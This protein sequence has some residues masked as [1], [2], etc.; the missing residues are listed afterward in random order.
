LPC[1]TEASE[2]GNERVC[3]PFL[4]DHA[5]PDRRNSMLRWHI[6]L[7]LG[8]ACLVG[9]LSAALADDRD[10]TPDEQSR[11]EAVLTAEGFVG[12]DDIEWEDG[13]W[14]VDDAETPDG[15]E[16]DLKL[17]QTFAIIEREED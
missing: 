6:G 4:L 10:P 15:E 17:D 13:M 7:V 8:T 1:A 2:A 11:I 12:W 14:E 3:K 16:Y 5:H 9:P